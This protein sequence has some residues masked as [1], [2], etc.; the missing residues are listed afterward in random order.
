MP[1]KRRSRLEASVDGLVLFIGDL[2]YAVGLQAL[3]NWAFE[4]YRE[5]TGKDPEWR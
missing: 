1:A 4:K 3:A 5:R 2:A